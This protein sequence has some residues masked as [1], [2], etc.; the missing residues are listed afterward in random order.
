M[1][2]LEKYVDKCIDSMLERY[3]IGDLQDRVFFAL[4]YMENS[5]AVKKLLWAIANG[6]KMVDE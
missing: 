3:A 1:E 5:N 6:E 4:G 2:S